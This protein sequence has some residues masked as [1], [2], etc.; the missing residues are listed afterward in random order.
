M[1]KKKAV[2]IYLDNETALALNRLR[3]EI[4]KKNSE[5]GMELPAPSIGWLARSLLRQKL[6]ITEDKKDSPYAV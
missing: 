3:E 6:G 4:R 2:S 1:N 5:T